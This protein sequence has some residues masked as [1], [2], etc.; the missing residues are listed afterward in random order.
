MTIIRTLRSRVSGENLASGMAEGGEQQPQT[1]PP[2]EAQETCRIV[3]VVRGGKLQIH[4]APV[5][6]PGDGE[7]R[8]KVEAW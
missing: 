7:V 3:Q 6:A 4:K 8:V 5:K 1:E 2:P